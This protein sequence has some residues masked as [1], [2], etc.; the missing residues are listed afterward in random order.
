[1]QTPLFIIKVTMQM[2]H[3]KQIVNNE[4]QFYHLKHC[5]I[6]ITLIEIYII[7]IIIIIHVIV[8]VNK[9]CID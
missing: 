6:N 5:N 8:S 7:S 2:K 4:K 9:Q 3:V 1:M